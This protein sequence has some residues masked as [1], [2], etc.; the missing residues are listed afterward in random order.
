MNRQ[1]RRELKKD[2]ILT[3][4][5]IADL[6]QR[7]FLIGAKEM[8]YNIIATLKNTKGIGPKTLDRI[9]KE[10]ERV[11]LIKDKEVHGVVN[12]EERTSKN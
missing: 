2:T 7:Y 10:L 12:L 3:H 11:H 5:F 6:K 9:F 8:F 1:Q 4:E